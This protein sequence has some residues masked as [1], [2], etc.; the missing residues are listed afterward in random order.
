MSPV[1]SLRDFPAR[2]RHR[3][4]LLYVLEATLI[5]LE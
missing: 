1:P 2:P 3:K 4:A 5:A